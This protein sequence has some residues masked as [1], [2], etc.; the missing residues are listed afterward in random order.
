M[1]VLVRDMS[2]KAV[3]VGWLM[4]TRTYRGLVVTG[5]AI[6]ALVL[7]V[8]FLVRRWRYTLPLV[9]G[10]TVAVRFSSLKLGLI[11]SVLAYALIVGLWAYR[12]LGKSQIDTWPELIHGLPRLWKLHSTWPHLVQGATVR[13]IRVTPSGVEARGKSDKNSVHLKKKELDLA[14]G[15]QAHRVV[16][17]PTSPWEFDVLVDWGLEFWGNDSGG[18]HILYGLVNSTQDII[19]VGITGIHRGTDPKMLSAFTEDQLARR[20]AKNR[21]KEHREEQPWAAEIADV[22]VLGIYPDREKVLEAETDMIRRLGSTL[23]NK[24]GNAYV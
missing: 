15:L 17:T 6:W 23:Y 1:R 24:V 7:F 12:L 21:M 3:L 18:K 9:L 5:M 10:L 14:A 11:A 13:N 20:A 16:I 22:D 4:G 2:A 19:Y 8:G